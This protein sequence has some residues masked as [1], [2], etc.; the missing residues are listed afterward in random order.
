MP[1]AEASSLGSVDPLLQWSRNHGLRFRPRQGTPSSRD[2]QLRPCPAP[3]AGS[4]PTSCYLW[5]GW[6]SSHTLMAL[7]L[8]APSDGMEQLG[9][10]SAVGVSGASTVSRSKQRLLP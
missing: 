3:I 1:L 6:Q 5:P 2:C 4:T 10:A 9:P 7:S 8:V